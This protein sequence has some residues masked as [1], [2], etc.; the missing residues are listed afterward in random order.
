MADGL[1]KETGA[2]LWIGHDTSVLPAEENHRSTGFSSFCD[3]LIVGASRTRQ[4][5]RRTKANMIG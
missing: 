3:C 4:P 5:T 2:Q 1:V